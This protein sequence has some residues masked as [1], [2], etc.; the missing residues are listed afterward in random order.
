MRNGT[1]TR[2]VAIWLV[3]AMFSACACLFLTCACL[4]V[5]GWAATARDT[6]P[7]ATDPHPRMITAHNALGPLAGR[8]REVARMMRRGAAPV[9]NL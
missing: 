4:G 2:R 7:L 1:D 8:L 5:R 9:R 6:A 3:G